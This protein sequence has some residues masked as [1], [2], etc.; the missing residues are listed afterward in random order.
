MATDHRGQ[1]LHAG[2]RTH[3]EMF[4]LGY[5]GMGFDGRGSS[6][7]PLLEPRP[8]WAFAEENEGGIIDDPYLMGRITGNIDRSIKGY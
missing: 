8:S 7:S 5:S 6:K 2:K 3:D 4:D 1:P